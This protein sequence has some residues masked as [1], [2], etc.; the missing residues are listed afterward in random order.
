MPV[1]RVVG[2]AVIVFDVVV[3]GGFGS[4]MRLSRAPARSRGTLCGQFV[5]KEKFMYTV[6]VRGMVEYR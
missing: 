1:V 6:V 4:K 2:A 3:A 5:I